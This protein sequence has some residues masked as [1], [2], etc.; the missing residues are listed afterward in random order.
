MATARSS[1]NAELRKS[2]IYAM[3]NH[4]NVSVAQLSDLFD[5]L[6]DIDSKKTRFFTVIFF[7]LF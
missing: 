7:L 5:E 6:S 3:G 1:D 4:E 2:A